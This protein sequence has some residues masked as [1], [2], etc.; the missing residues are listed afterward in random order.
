M[1]E[2][3]SPPRGW[4]GWRTYRKAGPSPPLISL[5]Q[6][7]DPEGDEEDLWLSFVMKVALLFFRW[8]SNLLL[9]SKVLAKGGK[10]VQNWCRFFYR[11]PKLPES[12]STQNGVMYV[13]HMRIVNEFFPLLHPAG[14]HCLQSAR[15]KL[16]FV[17]FADLHK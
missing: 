13:F 3:M 5:G 14:H 6:K 8:Q 16:H 11:S 9:C 1:T 17:F 7:K 10:G 15:W 2:G 12:R 4:C